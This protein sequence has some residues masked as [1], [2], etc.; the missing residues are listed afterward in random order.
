MNYAAARYKLGIAFFA[1]NV[2]HLF[3]EFWVQDRAR[4]WQDGVMMYCSK[5]LDSMPSL[6]QP[7]AAIGFH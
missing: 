1:L 6:K 4:D 2:G 7:I 3:D 5:Q